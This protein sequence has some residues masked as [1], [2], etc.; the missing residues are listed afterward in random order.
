MRPMKDVTNITK[1]KNR[2]GLELIC[3]LSWERWLFGVN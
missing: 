1:N 2:V 3:E